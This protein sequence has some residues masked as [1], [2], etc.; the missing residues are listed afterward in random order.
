MLIPL[1][2]QAKPIPHPYT[3][4]TL[5]APVPPPPPNLHSYL[6]LTPSRAPDSPKRR[7]T[8]RLSTSLPPVADIPAR[9]PGKKR[10]IKMRGV[11]QDPRGGR[12]A[13]VRFLTTYVLDRRHWGF[14]RFSIPASL[15]C[16]FPGAVDLQSWNWSWNGRGLSFLFRVRASNELLYFTTL[17]GSPLSM[18]RVS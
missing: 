12:D 14:W 10:T 7:I 8:R 5:P 16:E 13:E 15:T 3:S 18:L 6:T 9:C 11:R 2:G 4:P 17:H 1:V